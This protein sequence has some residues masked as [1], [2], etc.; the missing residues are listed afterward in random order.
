MGKRKQPPRVR[1]PR[2]AECE[3]IIEPW[4]YWVANGRQRWRGDKVIPLCRKCGEERIGPWSSPHDYGIIR[5]NPTQ[6][7]PVSEARGYGGG[8][9]IRHRMPGKVK[10]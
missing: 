7:F 3:R 1:I 5:L 10:R 6:R 8:W 4:G 9:G 2:C